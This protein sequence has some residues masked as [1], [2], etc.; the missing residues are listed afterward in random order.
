MKF[1][2]AIL[3]AIIIT[4]SATAPA[5]ADT[6]ETIRAYIDVDSS[7]KI[8]SVNGTSTGKSKSVQIYLLR[9]G[10]SISDIKNTVN[11]LNEVSYMGQAQKDVNG[12]FHDEFKYSGNAGN[13]KLCLKSGNV[14]K[15]Y[16]VDTTKTTGGSQLYRLKQLPTSYGAL[17]AQTV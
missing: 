5:F 11:M 1:I 13:Y 12:L 7:Q 9:D 14:Y 4:V 17:D 6:E 3:T 10:K 2:S 16:A 15:E 8:I